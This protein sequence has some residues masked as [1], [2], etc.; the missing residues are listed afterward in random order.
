MKHVKRPCPHLPPDEDRN[1]AIVHVARARFD[2]KLDTLATA[3]L[4][5]GRYIATFRVAL[6][7]VLIT[8]TPSNARN[9]Q[10]CDWVRV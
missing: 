5:V 10:S 2:G 8:Y 1:A 4:V 7:R 3:T 6:H 9:L